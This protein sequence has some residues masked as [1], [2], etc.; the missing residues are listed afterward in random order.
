MATRLILLPRH[1]SAPAIC[2]RVDET[3]HILSRQMLDDAHRLPAEEG[4]RD[5]VLVPGDSVR[6][7]WLDLPARNPVQA[8][9]AA[10][11]LLQEQVAWTG[12]TLH[13]ALGPVLADGAM[14][15]VAMVA[16]SQMQDWY[17]RCAEIGVTPHAMVPDHL[18]L[19]SP[20]SG[21]LD[22]AVHDGQWLVRGDQLAFAAEPDLAAHIVGERPRQFLAD[23]AQLEA[24]FAVA[25]ACSHPGQLDLLQYA[26][27]RD[28]GSTDA[29]RW[30][31]FALL[32]A[33]CMLSPVVLLGVQVI[34]DAMG[35]RWMERRADTLAAYQLPRPVP[36]G[37]DPSAA[38][39][40]HYRERVAPIT[41]ASQAAGMFTA[42]KAVPGA[43][44]DS[45]EY[46]EEDGLRMGVVLASE[47]ELDAIGQ[48][49]A[50]DGLAVVP[51][52]HQVVDGGLRAQV[53]VE[54]AR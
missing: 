31:R 38:L 36:V 11:I 50:R 5:V 30:R 22:I 42:I 12:D 48:Q 1:P 17:R 43:Q 16:E 10:R 29:P 6:A 33:A 52:G 9:A 23:P 45:L 34:R 26:H 21:T 7:Q 25:V 49:V 3:G 35:A 41:L 51:L 2:L 28:Q 24:R 44:L 47:A 18:L 32:A 27:A 54:G 20:E 14:R 15:L 53:A 37:A 46:R 39:H 40:A 19:A 13:I 4:A 8:L